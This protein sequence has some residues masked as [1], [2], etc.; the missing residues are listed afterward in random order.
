MEDAPDALRPQ[1]SSSTAESLIE[2]DSGL[3]E[4]EE[5]PKQG[6]VDYRDCV[7]LSETL[8]ANPF[9]AKRGEG[10]KIWVSIA[11]S[12]HSYGSK[13]KVQ[14]KSVR[15]RVNALLRQHVKDK[16]AS[17]SASGVSE[18]Y[19][20]KTKLL[21]QLHELKETGSD[22]KD[23]KK[24]ASEK[25]DALG[26]QMRQDALVN[27][28][29][30]S[31]SEEM[32]NARKRK[33]SIGE[34]LEEYLVGKNENEKKKLELENSIKKEEM[35]LKRKELDIKEREQR[36]RYLELTGEWPSW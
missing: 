3:E 36:L 19:D 4:T 15:D 33:R 30:T 14:W 23:L 13:Y 16:A 1:P 26:R 24:E 35:E 27:L 7:Y 11:E 8:A 10:E 2:P 28:S 9:A 12:V 18:S 31:S 20:M 25:L 29:E 34:A 5:W 21:D 22:E 32:R 6:T 17:L